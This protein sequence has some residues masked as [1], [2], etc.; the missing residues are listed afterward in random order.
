MI[1]IKQQICALMQVDEDV[2][3]I[4]SMPAQQQ[5]TSVDCGIF[6]MALLTWILFDE[7]TKTQRL[8]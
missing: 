8:D 3:K 4:N 6:A 1:L 5:K 7:G 2:I